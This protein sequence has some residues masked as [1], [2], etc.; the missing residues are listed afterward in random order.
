M[1]STSGLHIDQAPPLN[2]PFRFFGT[3]PLFLLLGGA[4]LLFWGDDLLVTPLAPPTIVLTHLAVLGWLAMVMVGAMYQMIPVLAGLP[5]PWIGLAPW[6][7]GLLCLGLLALVAE[8]GLGLH[9]WLLLVA[10]AGLG[11][12]VGLFL[13][14]TGV[15]LYRSPVRH[16]T[17]T[18]MAIA[19]T[20]LAGVLALGGL[21][22]GEY[23]HGFF[24]LDRQALVGIHLLWGLLGWVGTLILGVSMQVLPMFYVMPAYPPATGRRVL[25]W[26]SFTLLLLPASLLVTP[27]QPLLLWAAALP[28][29]AA[30]GLHV[31]TLASLAAARQRR[32]LDA[33]YRFWLLGGACVVLALGLLAL[34]PVWPGDGLRFLFGVLFLWGG[35]TSIILG[36]LH[37]IIPFLVWFHR[38]SSLAGL[39]DI[40]MMDDLVPAPMA[41]GHVPLHAT[42]L[43]LL[44]GAI[45][46]PALLPLAGLGLILSGATLA[47]LLAFALGQPVPEKPDLPDFASFF[48]DLPPPAS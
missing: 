2:I 13:L 27:E 9:R 11:G 31:R 3:A 24:D 18:A 44:A 33:T 40:P 23:A 1:I 37:K 32:I 20:S 36:M 48:K 22:L 42:V 26:W 15:A 35:A 5:M 38:Y 39:V 41:R 6:V 21:F 25:A 16:P 17:V 14:Q 43:F 19:A 29:V 34:W 7:H 8:I 12:A 30:L 10:S 47:W 45:V 4:A 46:W 28:G